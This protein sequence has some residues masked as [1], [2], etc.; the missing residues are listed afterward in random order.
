M[1]GGIGEDFSIR[2]LNYIGLGKL[3]PR[4]PV[5]VSGGAVVVAFGIVGVAPTVISTGDVGAALLAL[6]DEGVAMAS[7]FS[8]SRLRRQSAQS[9]PL[10]VPM[11]RA[12]SSD[13]A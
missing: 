11:A 10:L 9:L 12:V 5:I 7:L 1:R 4:R 13:S 2:I 6:R 8:R 3:E